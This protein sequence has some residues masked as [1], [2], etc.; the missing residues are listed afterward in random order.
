MEPS[1]GELD[2]D[3]L[4][5]LLE[6]ASF[7]PW[8]GSEESEDVLR[9]RFNDHARELA[10]RLLLPRDR[11][12]S[13]LLERVARN[14]LA[15]RVNDGDEVTVRGTAEFG[16]PVVSVTL[17]TRKPTGDVPCGC[18]GNGIAEDSD[19]WEIGGTQVCETCRLAYEVRTTAT[20]VLAWRTADM[21][22]CPRCALRGPRGDGDTSSLDLR[23]AAGA[24]CKSCRPGAETTR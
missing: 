8:T 12:Q 20:V 21:P 3:T 1:A 22:F 4:V 10:K 9:A 2:V 17:G 24:L 7:D 5:D 14:A 6:N 15:T 23:K 11:A 16:K 18:C 13:T 19:Y